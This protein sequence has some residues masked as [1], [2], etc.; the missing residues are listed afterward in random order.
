MKNLERFVLLFLLLGLSGAVVAQ[1]DDN[2]PKNFHQVNEKLYRSAQPNREEFEALK[3][4]GIKIIINLRAADDKAEDEKK[5]V[6][7]L[8]FRY[9]NIP[10]RRLGE[11]SNEQIEQVL[12]IINSSD[13]PVLIHCK[14]GKDRTGIAIAIYR[15]TRDGWTSKQAIDEAE[16]YGMRF[17]QRGMKKSIREYEKKYKGNSRVSFHDYHILDK[18]EARVVL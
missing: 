4:K 17:W 8:G 3:K 9:F 7:S 18:Y 15:I 12:S 10:F 2:L 14:Y 13:T 11:Q 6:E 1:S 16:K 5:L